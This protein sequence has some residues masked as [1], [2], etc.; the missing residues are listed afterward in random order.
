MLLTLLNHF[1]PFKCIVCSAKFN[2]KTIFTNHVA[3]V[4]DGEKPFKCEICNTRF[5]TKAMM[6]DHVS[7]VHE[8]EKPFKCEVCKAKFTE[9]SKITDHVCTV[10]EGKNFEV[11]KPSIAFMDNDYDHSL[12]G[13]D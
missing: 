10:H 7:S 12:A 8:V 5:A 13:F 9:K 1:V 2:N 3:S 6:T 4:H 11:E